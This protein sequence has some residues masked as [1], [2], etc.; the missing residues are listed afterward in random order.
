LK[1]PKQDY[2]SFDSTIDKLLSIRGISNKKEWLEPTFS[3]DKWLL[4]NVHDAALM[5]IKAMEKQSN[6]TVSYDID[7]DGICAGTEMVRYLRNYTD[8]VNF[9]YHQRDQGHGIAQQQVPDDTNLLIIVDSS[10]NEVD[11]CKRLSENNIEIIILDHHPKTLDNP[12]A[13]I[14]NPQLDNYP[15]KQLS[16]SGVVYKTI[17]TIDE[18]MSQDFCEEYQDLCGIGICG[19]IMS[20]DVPE[21]RNLVY[22]ALKN[23]NNPGIQAI[24]KIKWIRLDQVCTQ[25]IL[26]NISPIINACAR[27][28]CIEKIIE[29]LLEDNLDNCKELAKACIKLNEQRKKTEAKLFNSIK[30]RIDDSNKIII[31]KTTV[32]D[33]IDKGFNGLLAM[34]IAERYGKCC[35][36]IKKGVVVEEELSEECGLTKNVTTYSGSGRSINDIAFRELLEQTGLCNSLNGHSGAFGVEID[37]DNIPLLI[38]A[39]NKR[40][41]TLDN[42]ETVT[43]IYDIEIDKDDIN[44]KLIKDINYFN[45]ISGKDAEVVKVLIKNL[46]VLERKVMG[47]ELNSIKLVSSRVDMLKFRVNEMYGSDIN[48]GDLV[49]VIGSMNINVWWHNGFKKFITNLQVFID[50]YRLSSDK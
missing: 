22:N 14:V 32:D 20:M 40:L 1:Q 35:L 21:N 15:N 10:T 36:V 48:D 5:I 39:L 3:H 8:K 31:L 26:F 46:P 41:E 24:L 43:V 28:G 29:L 13:L 9:I 4:D 6:I 49:D 44:E 25:D 30:D 17:E 23:I 38:D 19:D 27:L 12:Y 42:D 34:K 11:E 50:D 45:Y 2:L 47:S 7:T 33:N 16:G 37:E 18:L